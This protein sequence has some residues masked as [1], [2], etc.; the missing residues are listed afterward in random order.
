MAEQVGH[1]VKRLKRIR[2]ENIKLGKLEP[3]EWRPLSRKEKEELFSRIDL[4]N[5]ELRN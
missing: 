3:G 2:V 4:D 5:T 1:E